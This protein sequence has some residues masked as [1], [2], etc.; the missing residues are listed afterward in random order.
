MH[1]LLL[2]TIVFQ[3]FLALWGDFLSNWGASP[4]AYIINVS[5]TK[6]IAP[7]IPSIPTTNDVII[8]NPMWKPNEAPIKFIMYIIAPPIIVL[9][10]NFKIFLIGNKNIFPIIKIAIAHPA[11]ISM[12]VNSIN[13]LLLY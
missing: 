11:T 10:T 12:F 9:N 7:G 4:I 13:T 8:F 2:F 1:I 5:I 3:Y 6:S